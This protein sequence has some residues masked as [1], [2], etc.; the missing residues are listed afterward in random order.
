MYGL[1]CG[2]GFLVFL[3]FLVKTDNTAYQALVLVWLGCGNDI[4]YFKFVF[5]SIFK[6]ASFRQLGQEVYIT[7]MIKMVSLHLMV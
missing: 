7:L 2:Y 3:V 6:P 5:I 1:V 4:S